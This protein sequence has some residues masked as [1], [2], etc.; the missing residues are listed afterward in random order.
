MTTFD[1]LRAAR[2]MEAAGMER[3]QAEAVATA[4]RAGQGDLATKADMAILRADID[5]VKAALRIMQWAMGLHAAVSL[6]TLGAV[7]WLAARLA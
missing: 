7:L 5:A 4:I 3:G 2:D 1:T 6:A